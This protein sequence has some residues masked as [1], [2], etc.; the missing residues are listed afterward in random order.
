MRLIA[1][2]LAT[3]TT[4][5]TAELDTAPLEAWLAKQ[6]RVRSLEADFIQERTLPALR[7]PVSTPGTFSMQKPGKM[8]WELGE[9]VKTLAVSDGTTMTLVDVE[10]KRA[11]QISA[12]SARAKP[13]TLLA[14]GALNGDLEG[15]KK[16]FDL[17]ESRVTNGIYQLTARPRDR[18]LRDK[19]QWVFLDIDPKTQLLR[20]MEIQ[21]DDKSRI[22]TIFSNSRINPRIPAERFTADLSGYKVQ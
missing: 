7:K 22:R 21:L 20:A 4:L 11:R 19:V 16:T 5:A 18:N 3:L 15:F 14:D 8:R 10:K 17:I 12:D 6:S 13:F 2:L 9:P 1:C